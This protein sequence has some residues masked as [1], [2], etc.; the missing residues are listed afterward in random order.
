MVLPI[1]M[2]MSIVEFV[3]KEEIK[4]EREREE[5]DKK[6]EEYT[7]IDNFPNLTIYDKIQI[8]I[9][10]SYYNDEDK[11]RDYSI[12]NKKNNKSIPITNNKKIFFLF[13]YKYQ[14]IINFN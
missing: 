3:P 5:K 4:K 7:F 9:Y 10:E 11:R 2:N 14:K 1:M 13:L 6:E 8:L 12:I